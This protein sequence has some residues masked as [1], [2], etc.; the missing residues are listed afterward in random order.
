MLGIS[1]REVKD[2]FQCLESIRDIMIAS[3]V[4]IVLPKIDLC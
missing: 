3:E 4:L 1:S 2:E